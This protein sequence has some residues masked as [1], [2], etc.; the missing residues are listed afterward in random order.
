MIMLMLLMGL[1][2]Y[3]LGL[4]AGRERRAR[5]EVERLNVEVSG[6]LTRLQKR[7][8]STDVSKLPVLR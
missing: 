8:L 6:T 1:P 5:S 7:W 2:A 3:A 4:V